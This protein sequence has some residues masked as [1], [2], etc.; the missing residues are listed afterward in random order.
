MNIVQAEDV[1]LV[2]NYHVRYYAMDPIALY[3][4]DGKPLINRNS[5]TTVK[6][7]TVGK[8]LYELCGV[9]TCFPITK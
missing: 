4:S 1:E 6:R 3:I 2:Q 5:N 9:I 7:I 8:M